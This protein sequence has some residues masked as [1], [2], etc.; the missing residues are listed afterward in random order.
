MINRSTARIG[1]TFTF[2]ASSNEPPQTDNRN[3]EVIFGAINKVAN[4]DIY[5][6]QRPV[7]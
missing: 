6:D 4:S 1:W 5:T 2:F 3:S 7:Q